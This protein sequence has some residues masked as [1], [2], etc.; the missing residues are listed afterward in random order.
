MSVRINLLNNPSGRRPTTGY[1]LLGTG[2]IG[3]D[4]AQDTYAQASASQGSASFGIIIESTTVAA[5]LVAGQTYTFSAYVYGNVTSAG[6]SVQGAGVASG[7]TFV[8]TPAGSFVRLSTTFVAAASGAVNFYILN[9]AAVVSGN[10][11]AF[12]DAL[13]EKVATAGTYFDG[14]YLLA[15][16]AGTADNSKSTQYVPVLTATP[17]TD[18]SPAPRIIVTVDDLPPAITTLTMFRLADGRTF[19]VRGAVSVPVAGGFAVPDVEAPFQVAAGY[20][21]QMFASGVDQGYSVTVSTTLTVTDCWVHNTLDPTGAVMIDITDASGKSLNRPIDGEVFYP[22]GRSLGVLISGRRRGLQGVDMF[23]ST[24]DATVATKFEAMLGGYTDD[25]Q[26]IPILCVRTPPYLDIP[27]TFYA[28]MLSPRKLP[29]NVHMGGTLRN[30]AAS[31]D[32]LAPPA[33]GL[34]VALLSR[35]DIDFFYATRNAIDAAYSSRLALDRDY[36]K[37]GLV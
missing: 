25:D 7:G 17:A 12:R 32:E 6:V 36:T 35:D 28:G 18:A 8:T 19:K 9:G 27:R 5:K 23:F 1:V 21:V 30:W 4:P 15:Y 33:P 3:Q 31:A 34:V 16:W 37:A 13:V 26:M 29:I 14:T 11:V 20:R 2:A 24:L 22:E 10:I